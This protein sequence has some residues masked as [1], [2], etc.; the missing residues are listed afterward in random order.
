MNGFVSMVVRRYLRSRRGFTRVVTLFSVLGILLGVAALIVVLA[1]MSGFRQELMDRILGVS[2]HAT[3]Q[4]EG[5]QAPAARVLADELVKVQGVAS[6]TPY[7]SGQ[8][9][10]TSQGRATGAFLRGVE[11]DPLAG[12]GQNVA[13][14]GNKLGETD[15]LLVGSGL[16]GQLGLLPGAG[17]TL[18][19]PEGA[20]TIVGFVPRTGQF[21]VAGTF[22]VGM[23]QFDNALI[24][25]KMEDVQR[26]LGRREA[27]DALEIR[28]DD[29]QKI[30]V[31]T[32][33]ILEVADRFAENPMDVTLVPWTVTNAEFFRALQVERV[34]MF[35]ILSLIVVVAAFNIIT[36]QMM[37]VNDKMGD[38][39]IL[40]T[41]GATQRQIRRIFLFNGLLLG[42]IGVLG[43]I[44]L[45]MLIVWRMAE[46]VDLIRALTGVNLFPSEVYFLS[47]LPG[48]ISITDMVN[49]VG[50]AMLLTVLASLYPAWKAS[51]LNPVELLR[52]G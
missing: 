3:L 26:F 41:M 13:L 30:E 31:V 43:G 11:G 50:M 23:I 17:V 25:G 24:L 7:V 18:L 29:P 4:I 49:V 46:L 12:M 16:A 47:E 2:G 20:R 51:K 22:N 45:G 19:S 32:P 27:V 14:L 48:K 40:R 35:I 42:G 15:Q 36:G 1:V 21:G 28:L 10:V 52:R 39:A 6:A 44:L 8:V 33:H 34:T 38:I 5:L 37:L 9:M